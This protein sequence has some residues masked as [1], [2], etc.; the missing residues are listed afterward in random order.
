[1]LAKLRR[2]AEEEQGFTS[3]GATTGTGT[4]TA[5]APSDSRGRACR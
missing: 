2:R 4:T 1:M 5:G 3:T